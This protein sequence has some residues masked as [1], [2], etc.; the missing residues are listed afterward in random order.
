[1][2]KPNRMVTAKSGAI[3][4]DVPRFEQ[5][6]DVTCGPTCLT[7]VYRY[8]GLEKSL[9]DVIRETPRNPDG[10]T[11]AVYLGIDAM[12][13]GFH[14][15]IYSYNLRVFDPSWSRFNVP[16]LIEKLGERKKAVTSKRL[17]RS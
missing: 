17:R 5:P 1:M 12:R 14:P 6:D 15:V 2:T 11:L 7:Q 16:Q 8:F 13:N 4:L 3:L 9:K 10:G